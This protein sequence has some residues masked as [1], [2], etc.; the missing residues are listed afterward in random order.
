[1]RR[2]NQYGKVNCMFHG[3]CAARH[4]PRRTFVCA[5]KLRQRW[6]QAIVAEVFIP[7]KITGS[8][9]GKPQIAEGLPA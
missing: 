3:A 9:A 4:I 6:R 8:A 2:F 5:N 1:V 7:E